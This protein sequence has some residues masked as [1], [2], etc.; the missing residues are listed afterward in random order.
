MAPE[1]IGV[2]EVW[3]AANGTGV[4]VAVVDTG[5][6]YEDHSEPVRLRTFAAAPDFAGTDFLDP[7]DSYDMDDHAN[8]DY[9]HG[10][11][12]A[13]TIAESTN[14]GIGGAGIAPGARI[15]PVKVCGPN[16]NPVQ[17]YGCPVPDCR[18]MRGH[19]TPGHS[20]TWA[21]VAAGLDRGQRAAL[22]QPNAVVVVALPGTR[23][24][25]AA[26]SLRRPVCVAGRDR[27]Q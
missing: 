14:N 9:G 23:E 20:S 18:R 12:V 11:H 26:M 10:T 5:V 24:I 17:V 27:S 21:S 3:Q 8:D 4:K 19:S 6:A 2:G 22:M 16:P 7:H 13:G 15:M 1:R 25:R